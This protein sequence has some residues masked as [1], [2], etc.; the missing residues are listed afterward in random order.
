MTVPIEWQLSTA[1]LAVL[2]AL[3]AARS[4]GMRIGIGIM[5]WGAW[6]REPV[7]VGVG[8]LWAWLLQ[9]ERPDDTDTGDGNGNGRDK[10]A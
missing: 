3:V 7:V 4:P 10:Y 2:C 9:P 6:L 1:L 8:V 5:F